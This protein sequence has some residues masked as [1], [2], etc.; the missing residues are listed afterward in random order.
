MADLNPREEIVGLMRGFMACPLITALGKHRVL[1]RML[2]GPFR[3]AEFRTVANLTLLGHAIDYLLSLGLIERGEA[4]EYRT[5]ELGQKVFSRYGSFVLLHSYRDLLANLEALLFQR[6]T[7]Q[8]ACDRRDNVIGSGLTNGRKFFPRAL[9]MLD[10]VKPGVIAD[11]ACGDG[12]FLDQVIS[13]HPEVDVIASDISEAAIQETI[14]NLRA[15]RPEKKIE[16]ILTDALNVT[17]WAPVV[18]EH[19]QERG[20]AV[21]SMWYLL[22]EVSE[23]CWQ[24]IV[25]FLRRIHQVCPQAH[26]LIGEIVNIPPNVLAASRHG[27][28]M[29]EFLLFHSASGQGVLTW[30]ELC[31]VRQQIPYDLVDEALFDQVYD[32]SRQIPTSLVWHLKP[33]GE[34]R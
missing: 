28:I 15:K 33:K 30:H 11:I 20:T 12:T 2:A 26:L 9:A 7:P 16:T 1:D 34:V 10:D 29:P 6:E 3:L 13:R 22:H 32:G 23:R 24:R 17:Q 19:A 14:R 4:H 25:H 31:D 18:A 8:P 27:S 5:T 21:I